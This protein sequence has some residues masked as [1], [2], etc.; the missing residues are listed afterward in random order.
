MFILP[1][2]SLVSTFLPVVMSMT[3]LPL[4]RREAVEGEGGT[5]RLLNKINVRWE[6]AGQ[7]G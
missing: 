5:A 1:K 4:H 7:G 2:H 6:R 3:F